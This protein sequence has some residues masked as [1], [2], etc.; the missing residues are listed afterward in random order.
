MP[1]L[2]KAVFKAVCRDCASDPD[3][4]IPPFKVTRAPHPAADT[5]PRFRNAMADEPPSFEPHGK[6]PAN[7]E[8]FDSIGARGE[9]KR[10][11]M[12]QTGHARFALWQT[13]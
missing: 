3:K 7:T 4:A 1:T 13:D 9:W 5:D 12:E 6:D 2:K 11:H 8:K 10:L